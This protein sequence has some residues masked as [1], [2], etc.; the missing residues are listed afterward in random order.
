MNQLRRP[1]LSGRDGEPVADQALS[2]VVDPEAGGVVVGTPL[3]SVWDGRPT[4]TRSLHGSWGVVRNRRGSSRDEGGKKVGAGG[5]PEIWDDDRA[6]P[7]RA[8]GKGDD[9][10]AQVVT[11]EGQQER[12]LRQV[13]VLGRTGQVPVLTPDDEA[14]VLDLVSHADDLWSPDER[15]FE[16]R[17]IVSSTP[18]LDP[19]QHVGRRV[20]GIADGAGAPDVPIEGDAFGESLDDP[21]RAEAGLTRWGDTVLVSPS[22]DE[23]PSRSGVSVDPVSRRVRRGLYG[24]VI[25]PVIEYFRG[26]SGPAQREASPLAT[27]GTFYQ[28]DRFSQRPHRRVKPIRL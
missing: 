22:A 8:A 4:T 9:Q 23:L 27:L 6:A 26:R 5:I 28:P 13:Q 24:H 25:R 18:G 3:E 15:E 20:P 10:G 12:T 21:R 2:P 17:V 16:G 1:P 19:K 7:L 14:P 11:R